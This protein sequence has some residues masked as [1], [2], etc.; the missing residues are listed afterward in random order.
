MSEERR[1]SD[2]T[3]TLLM[4]KLSG[5]DNKLD[6]LSMLVN[7]HEV[8]IASAKTL[9]RVAQFVGWPAL[10]GMLHGLWKN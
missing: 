2:H 6:T 8:D 3:F 1:S 7:K 4:D 10:L 9:G 5:M